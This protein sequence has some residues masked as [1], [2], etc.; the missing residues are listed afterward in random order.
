MEL[1]LFEFMEKGF[2]ARLKVVQPPRER[3]EINAKRLSTL[4]KM[5]TPES[6]VLKEEIV[7]YT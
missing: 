1:A 6:R 7:L 4:G 3:R 5:E 2:L